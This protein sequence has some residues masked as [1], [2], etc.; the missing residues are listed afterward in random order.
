MKKK[1]YKKHLALLLTTTILLTG[2]PVQHIQASQ[3]V[4]LSNTKI[5]LKAGTSKT[6]TLK[7]NKKKTTWKIVSGKKYIRLKSKKKCSVMIAAV[8]P[9]KAKIQAK[10]GKKTLRFWN[11]NDIPIFLPAQQRSVSLGKLLKAIL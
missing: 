9:G 11:T 10:A 5:T 3:T 7:N 2:M 6:L 1:T 4:K 8:K